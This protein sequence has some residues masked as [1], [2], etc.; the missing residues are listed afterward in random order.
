MRRLIS[1]RTFLAIFAVLMF[2]GCSC[3]DSSSTVESEPK[4]KRVTITVDQLAQSM[5][6]N[7]SPEVLSWY[8]TDFSR[9]LVRVIHGYPVEELRESAHDFV[10][11]IEGAQPNVVLIVGSQEAT[12]N[13]FDVYAFAQ[14]NEEGEQVLGFV[15][16]N[17]YPIWQ[18]FEDE[19]EAFEDLMIAL[20]SHEAF[21]H[22]EQSLGMMMD[23]DPSARAR[24]ETE[25]FHDTAHVLGAMLSEGR[26]LFVTSVYAAVPLWTHRMGGCD[27]EHE[28]W[29]ELGKM[30]SGQEHGW[31]ELYDAHQLTLDSE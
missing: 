20:I 27:L 23:D 6:D 9:T 12:S 13:I 26:E 4:V 15:A 7:V 16:A 18:E 21:H 10:H 11:P 31:Q 1:S 19:P 8:M 29:V 28:A 14:I 3:T 25:A 22:T 30:Q 2:A 24:R 17:L 5:G